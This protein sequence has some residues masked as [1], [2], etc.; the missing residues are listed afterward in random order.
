MLLN[1]IFIKFSETMTTKLR[2]RGDNI[3]D[4]EMI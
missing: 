1:L 2:T 4:C 3:R